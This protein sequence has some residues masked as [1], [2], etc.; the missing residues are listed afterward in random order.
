MKKIE[1]VKSMHNII[2]TIDDE[3]AYQKWAYVVPDGATTEDFEHIAANE[4]LYN[5]TTVLFTTII[6]AYG[7]GGYVASDKAEKEINQAHLHILESFYSDC[8]TFWR[9]QSV[10]YPE[11]NVLED[12]KRLTTNPYIAYH[13]HKLDA[14]TKEYFIKS[15]S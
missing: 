8:L 12:I 2:S 9:S 5:S 4:E 11:A 3:R 13:S 10:D 15:K 14:Y 1:L 7:G 6:K